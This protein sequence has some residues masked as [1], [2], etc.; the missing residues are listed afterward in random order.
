MTSIVELFC[1]AQ[2]TS[3]LNRQGAKKFEAEVSVVRAIKA[4]LIRKL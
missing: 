1:E 2:S 4:L 3:I